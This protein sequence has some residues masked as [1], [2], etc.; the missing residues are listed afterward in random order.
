MC[1]VKNSL[2]F[3]SFLILSCRPFSASEPVLEQNNNFPQEEG[4]VTI[5]LDGSAPASRAIN[6]T[7]AMMSCDYFE[8]VFLYNFD[9]ANYRVARGAW[10]IGEGAGVSG[11]YRDQTGVN[12]GD[13][14]SNPALGAG[15]AILFAGKGDRTLLAIGRLRMV[16]NLASTFITSESKSVTFSLNAITA[17]ISETASNSSFLTAALD[18][19]GSYQN[20]SPSNTNII[21]T[22]IAGRDF[23]LFKLVQNVPSIKAQY[24][25]DLHSGS[26]PFS[27][28]YDGIRIADYPTVEKKQ[29]NYYVPHGVAVQKPT[30]ILDNKTTVSMDN[31]NLPGD[32][33]NKTVNFTFN[34][35]STI[36]GSVFSLVFS[37]PVYAL[38]DGSRWY[39]RPGYGSGR[40]D[41][42]DGLEGSGSAIL[43]GTGDV[44][45]GGG[46]DYV[47][48]ITR[49]P[50]TWHYFPAVTGDPSRLFN[51]DGLEVELRYP[52]GTKFKDIDNNEL[53]FIIGNYYV[54]PGVW[55][56]D[57][58]WYGNVVI[59]VEFTDTDGHIYRA[60]FCVL[61]S[62][63]VYD[64]TD[65]VDNI[66]IVAINPSN[67]WDSCEAQF[68]RI[69]QDK[70]YEGKSIIIVVKDSFNIVNVNYTGVARLIFVM[71]GA[72]D[73]VIGRGPE[74]GD[75]ASIVIWRP[76]NLDTPPTYNLFYFGTWPYDAPGSQLIDSSSNPVT[77]YP[78]T[79]QAGGLNTDD[80]NTSSY[81][82]K[83]IR[84]G[85]LANGGIYNVQTSDDITVLNRD[86]LH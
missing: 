23:P 24:V 31:N 48:V 33:F 34:T 3:L 56:F 71:A 76:T 1:K 2:I 59:T 8:V 78:F 35:Y 7:L 66:L 77:T 21:L 61:V 65:I 19:V 5:Y 28:Y 11:V 10:N 74:S 32:L 18:T 46:G 72:P 62:N 17:G 29:P 58:Q 52:D 6:R 75:L 36:G 70:A 30:L 54:T 9:N 4:F 60:I 20:V 84:N 41:L 39:I 82:L 80:S 45:I 83:M 64:F 15:S 14:S 26:E 51:I 27:D 86:L 38:A 50:Y 53:K 79:I 25:F 73:V 37:I 44:E 43:I 85:H 22:D 40:Y 57:N 16:D 55:G 69:I 63:L 47:M 81:D 68:T 13:V 42:D 67:P 49:K 12:Y